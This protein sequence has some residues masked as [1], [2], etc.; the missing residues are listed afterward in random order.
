MLSAMRASYPVYL[1]F[2]IFPTLAEGH[3]MKITNTKLFITPPL[4]SFARC[5]RYSLHVQSVNEIF[6]ISVLTVVLNQEFVLF[7]LT[8]LSRLSGSRN[9]GKGGDSCKEQIG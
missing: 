7:G 4:S 6:F 2:V 8:A 3:L 9:V 5:T 1:V